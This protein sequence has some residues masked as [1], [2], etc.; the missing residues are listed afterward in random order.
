M[1]FERAKVSFHTGRDEALV[2]KQVDLEREMSA[3]R[4]ETEALQRELEEVRAEIEWVK[5][6]QQTIEDAEKQL[7]LQVVGGARHSGSSP[8]EPSSSRPRK[9]LRQTHTSSQCRPMTLPFAAEQG[10]I[11]VG[12]GSEQDPIYVGSESEGGDDASTMHDA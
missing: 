10:P 1:S 3:A 11:H 2:S 8:S 7:Q 4:Q 12:S 6:D 5:R 9:R